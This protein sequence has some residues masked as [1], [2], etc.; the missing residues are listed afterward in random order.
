M[1]DEWMDYVVTEWLPGWF[2][3]KNVDR[4]VWM[5]RGNISGSAAL[6]SLGR[7]I[8][9]ESG[10]SCMSL[11]VTLPAGEETG[12]LGEWCAP[13]W[14]GS[15]WVPVPRQACSPTHPSS[16]A[17]GCLR[18]VCSEVMHGFLMLP[19]VCLLNGYKIPRTACLGLIKRECQWILVVLL[20]DVHEA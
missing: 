12:K 10:A 4:L 18:V 11:P 6:Q 17:A 19:D 16:C 2:L 20:I 1:G 9:W 15:C 7:R 8:S 3:D 14:P 13:S 5:Q